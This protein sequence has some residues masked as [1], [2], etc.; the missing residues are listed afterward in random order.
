V[1]LGEAGEFSAPRLHRNVG[2]L[3]VLHNREREMNRIE[4]RLPDGRKKSLSAGGQNVL[5]HSVIEDFCSRYTPDGYVCYLGDAGEKITAEERDY[6]ESLGVTINTHGKMPDVVVHLKDKN[7]LVLIEAVT[8]HGPIDNKRKRELEKL[9]ADASADLVF[10][11]AFST[12]KV[13]VKYLRDIAWETDVWLAENPSHLIHFN[14]E[15]FL[16]PY[17]S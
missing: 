8:S 12:R 16:G 4:V 15:K 13:M 2:S 11:T 7:W 6:L 5:I 9:F 14:G 10:I 17:E 1:K 3:R